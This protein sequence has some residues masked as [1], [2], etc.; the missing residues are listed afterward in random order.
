MFI[1]DCFSSD[2]VLQLGNNKSENHQRYTD[3]QT[4]IT[5]IIIKFDEISKDKAEWWHRTDN[6]LKFVFACKNVC[7]PR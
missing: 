6:R 7:L 2:K 1:T 3:P 5:N 4:T